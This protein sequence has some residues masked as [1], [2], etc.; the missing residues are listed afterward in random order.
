MSRPGHVRELRYLQ[1]RR[2]NCLTWACAC[3]RRR[4]LGDAQIR[5]PQAPLADQAIGHLIAVGSSLAL[6]GKVMALG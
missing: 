6:V 3:H 4:P 1:R 5:L 2:L